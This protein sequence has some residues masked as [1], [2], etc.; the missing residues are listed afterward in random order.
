MIAEIDGC[1]QRAD[2]GITSDPINRSK[3]GL[4]T[5]IG[6][7]CRQKRR[8]LR[9]QQ[10][11]INQR[12]IHILIELFPQNSRVWRSAYKRQGRYL[13]ANLYLIGVAIG[14]RQLSP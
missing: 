11:G 4:P 6:T 14:V 2:L 8:L 10:K 12:E 3:P 9:P 5:R 1:P 13:L 7:H